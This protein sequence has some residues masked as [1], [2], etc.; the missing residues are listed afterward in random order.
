MVRVLALLVVVA[1][2]ALA[3]RGTYSG[4]RSGCLSVDTIDRSIRE[5]YCD[6]PLFVTFVPKTEENTL[7]DNICYTYF[8]LPDDPNTFQIYESRV[9]CDGSSDVVSFIG[10]QFDLGVQRYANPYCTS[11]EIYFGYAGCDTYLVYSCNNFGNCNNYGS[12]PC[13][14]GISAQCRSIGLSCLRKVEEIVSDNCLPDLE[15][16]V[17]P[18]KLPNRCVT[19]QNCLN[20]TAGNQFYKALGFTGPIGVYR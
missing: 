9:F 5:N 7:L 12:S 17:L 15:Y 1:G 6:Q 10:T 14:Y 19:Q 3:K 13:I 8:P 2:C 4:N 18:M 20:P 11:S 16:Y